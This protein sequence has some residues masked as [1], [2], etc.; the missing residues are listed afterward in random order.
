[1]YSET[2]NLTYRSFIGDD[3][4]SDLFEE[5]MKEGVIDEDFEPSIGSCLKISISVEATTIDSAALFNQLPQ[6]IYGVTWTSIESAR[7]GVAL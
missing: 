7:G 3:V 4:F 2:Q 6:R 5:L 1:M